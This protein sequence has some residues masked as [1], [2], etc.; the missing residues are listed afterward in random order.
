MSSLLI[1]ILF[2]VKKKKCWYGECGH[3][4]MH[5]RKCMPSY[6]LCMAYSIAS[7]SFSVIFQDCL[8]VNMKYA[9]KLLMWLTNAEA[10]QLV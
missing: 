6:S 1:S 7:Y 9:I 10:T 5:R 8:V 3:G 4:F 2:V